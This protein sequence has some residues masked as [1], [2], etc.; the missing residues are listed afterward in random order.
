MQTIKLDKKTIIYL[1]CYAVLIL[2]LVVV[3]P[4]QIRK[5][6]SLRSKIGELK[7]NIV[8]FNNDVAAKDI[9]DAEK[10][11]ITELEIPNLAGKIINPQDIFIISA[12]VTNKAKENDVDILELSHRRPQLYKK[13]PEG[14]FFH[15]PIKISAKARFHDLGKFFECIRK[16]RLFFRSKRSNA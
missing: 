13:T 4:L 8:D 12:Y 6:A 10:K 1:A 5:I 2:D 11:K 14:N 7:K 15:R 9:L 16:S 3:L